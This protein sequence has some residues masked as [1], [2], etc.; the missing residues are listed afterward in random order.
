[1]DRSCESLP[2]AVAADLQ[3]IGNRGLRH[4]TAA[5]HADAAGLRHCREINHGDDQKQGQKA[6]EQ[7]G[8]NGHG[9]RSAAERLGTAL[10]SIIA[11]MGTGSEKRCRNIAVFVPVR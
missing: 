8:G 4:A 5:E 3:A 1:M 2:D 11:G 10:A 7:K 9:F 6:P